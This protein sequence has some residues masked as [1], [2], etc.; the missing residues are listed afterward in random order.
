MACSIFA[1]AVSNEFKLVVMITFTFVY[2]N[3]Y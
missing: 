3:K 1:P 2:R